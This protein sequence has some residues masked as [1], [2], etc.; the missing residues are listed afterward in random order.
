M[1]LR[2]CEIGKNMTQSSWKTFVKYSV[3]DMRPVTFAIISAV[4]LR[5]P[6]EALRTFW[7]PETELAFSL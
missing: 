3:E 1:S 7:K 4:I 6:I 5:K 2:G